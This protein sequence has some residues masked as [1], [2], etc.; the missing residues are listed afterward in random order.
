MHH[1]EAIMLP[2]EFVLII[3]LSCL[4]YDIGNRGKVHPLE[5]L[6]PA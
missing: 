3:T 6:H 2:S 1:F 5:F 4:P